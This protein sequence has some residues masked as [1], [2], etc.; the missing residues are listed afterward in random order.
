[1]WKTV[2]HVNYW[3]YYE[4]PFQKVPRKLKLPL[5]CR[6]LLKMFY[7]RYVLA[8]Y[9]S[10][11]HIEVLN[12]W[13]YKNE[14]I[15]I[16]FRVTVPRHVLYWK[17]V[18]N[19]K[20]FLAMLHNAQWTPWKHISLQPQNHVTLTLDIWVIVQILFFTLKLTGEVWNSTYCIIV[21]SLQGTSILL[22]INK[23]KSQRSLNWSLLLE[24]GVWET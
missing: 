15:L 9:S 2:E 12:L 16:S 22:N 8:G 24:S 19:L 6:N 11:W 13:W 3:Y 1:M 18:A 23:K 7:K 4:K 14:V 5:L 21:R 17:C 10:F 20:I